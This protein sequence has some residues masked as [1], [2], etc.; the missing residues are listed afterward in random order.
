MFFKPSSI[1]AS[2]SC[3]ASATSKST[4]DTPTTSSSLSHSVPPCTPSTSHDGNLHDGGPLLDGLYSHL[5]TRAG[6]N[7]GKHAARQ[8]T[9]YI[10]KYLYWFNNKA[11]EERA[12]LQTAPV[13]PYLEKMQEGGIGYSGILHRILA[14]KAALYYMKLVVSY[15]LLVLFKQTTGSLCLPEDGGGL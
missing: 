6:G 15:L 2:K 1:S 9:C 4:V 14:H 13:V 5:R 11:V 10:G 12:L 7:R 8:I 3:S